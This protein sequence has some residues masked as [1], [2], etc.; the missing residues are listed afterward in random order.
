MGVFFTY[1]FALSF[2]FLDDFL[3]SFY[4]SDYDEDESLLSELLELPLWLLSYYYFSSIC[5]SS[6]FF[7]LLNKSLLMKLIELLMIK[8]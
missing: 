1:F 5:I 8:S 2:Y 3:S 6:I 4:E 7:A